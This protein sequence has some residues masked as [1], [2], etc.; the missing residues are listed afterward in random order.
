M[1]DIMVAG[2]NNLSKDD[3]DKITDGLRQTR[4]LGSSDT[5]SDSGAPTPAA[6]LQPQ[7]NPGED[8]CKIACD[9]T[10]AAAAAWCTANTAGLGLAACL[11]AA[12]RAR[13]LCRDQC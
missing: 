8:L 12:E 1:A 11:A 4:V 9:A 2:W 3:Q 7:W 10:A 5:I 6:H 13:E